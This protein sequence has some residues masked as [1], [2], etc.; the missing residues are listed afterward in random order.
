MMNMRNMRAFFLGFW[1]AGL[2]GCGSDDG[3]GP[4]GSGGA[5]GTSASPNEY[6]P[7][8][9]V[10]SCFGDCPKGE[11]DNFGT[12]CKDVYSEP[13]TEGSSYCGARDGSYCLV[14]D[15]GDPHMYAVQCTAG[16][17]VIR[18]CPSQCGNSTSPFDC[19]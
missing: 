15:G 14:M 16:K 17:T 11:C 19:R 8:L 4:S 12:A 2:V 3:G 9:E 7:G 1:A 18:G 10:S 13:L 6:P 5:G